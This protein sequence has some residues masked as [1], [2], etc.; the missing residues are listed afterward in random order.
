MRFLI[1]SHVWEPE[2][3][4]PQRRWAWLT[5]VLTG[6]GHEVDVVAPPPHHPK[7]RLLSDDLAR[8]SWRNGPGSNGEHIWR[9]IHAPH[10]N[11]TWPDLVDHLHFSRGPDGKPEG[12]HVKGVIFATLAAISQG[13][14][15]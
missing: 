10:G 13:A 5:S 3:G 8:R 9:T 2:V 4:V 15:S 11:A 1:I 14:P 6:A 7:G 12:R